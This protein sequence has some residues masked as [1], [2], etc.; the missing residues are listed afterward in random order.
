MIYF[1]C[2]VNQLSNELKSWPYNFVQS[3]AF[4]PANERGTVLGS[5]QVNDWYILTNLTSLKSI[6]F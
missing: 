5:F 4:V 1:S 2:L 3:K 6:I